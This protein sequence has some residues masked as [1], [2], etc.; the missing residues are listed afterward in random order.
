MSKE[1]VLAR[2]LENHKAE[3]RN[4]SRTGVTYT[5][6]KQNV[7]L[8]DKTYNDLLSRLHSARMS[9]ELKVSG[10]QILDRAEPPKDPSE[11]QPVRNMVVA[12]FL[13][14]VLGVG[15]ALLRENMDRGVKSPQDAAQYLKLPL[16]TVVPGI[17][18]SQGVGREEGRAQLV[19]V[20]Q[21]RSHAAECYRNLR[22][23]IL[24]SSG[25]PVPRTIVVTSAVAGEGKSTT[26]ANLAVVMAQTGRKT[27]LIDADLRRPALQRYFVRKGNPGILGLL[28]DGCR[29]EEAVQASGIENLDLLLCTGVPPDPS[30]LLGS[31]RTLGLIETL[32]SRYEVIILDS[33]VVISVPDAVILAARAEAVIMVHRPGA[34]ERSMVHHARE[35]LD[36]VNANMLGLVMNNV[37]VKSGDYRYA[38][39]MY[40]GYGTE[41]DV[42]ARPEKAKRGKS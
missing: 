4:L 38:E 12:V 17:A 16:L 29:L 30:E 3:I 9:G 35:K 20:Q 31:A 32:K 5:L 42:Q 24:F 27:M 25:K 28:Q 14:L 8:N 23:S 40:Y 37:D 6:L 34:A 22:T 2:T 13:G 18:L 33:P 10:V 39:Y 15:L 1:K 7:D 19:T 26:A 41:A 36:E 21:P 11:P